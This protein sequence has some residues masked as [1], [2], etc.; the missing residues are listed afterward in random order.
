MD[1]ASISVKRRGFGVKLR[2]HRAQFTWMAG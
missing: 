1:W 2:R